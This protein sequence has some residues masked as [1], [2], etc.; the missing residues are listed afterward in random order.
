MTEHATGRD[1]GA[2]QCRHCDAV[3]VEEE[4]AHIMRCPECDTRAT[5][6][7]SKDAE[8]SWIALLLSMLLYVGAWFLPLW[9]MDIAG[10]P[11]VAM[12]ARDVVSR[13]WR[14]G[15]VEAAVV[16]AMV[17]IVLPWCR[18]AAMGSL[19]VAD[20]HA[21]RAHAV[22]RSRVLATLHAVERWMTL[23]ILATMFL[24][25]CL[26][27]HAGFTTAGLDIGLYLLWASSGLAALSMLAFDGRR[28]WNPA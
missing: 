1:A 3:W 19:L 24:V 11:E 10:Q 22:L 4:G 2:I 27:Q 25:A 8:L 12:T 9:H 7:W 14:Q 18:F 17:N 26:R 5:A 20:H 6:W 15:S 28:I 23:D 16:A 13:L 21:M